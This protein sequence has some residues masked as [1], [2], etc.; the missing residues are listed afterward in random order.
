MSSIFTKIIQGGIPCERLLETESE[1][2]FLDINPKSKGHALVV[3]KRE[4]ARLED[5]PPEEAAALMKTLQRVAT[6]VSRS[7]ESVDYNV[8]LNNGPDAG[9]EVFHVHFHIIPRPPGSSRRDQV[10][11]AEGELG[12]VGAAIRACLD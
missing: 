6:A 10:T 8:V 9:Q 7:Q 2:S 11:Y 3:P 12:Q 1:F 4:V 5:L